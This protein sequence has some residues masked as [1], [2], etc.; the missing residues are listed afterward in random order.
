MITSEREK[1]Q[2]ELQSL[3]ESRTFETRT[4]SIYS[5]PDFTLF[6]TIKNIYGRD[7][8][9]IFSHN[10]KFFACISDSDHMIRIYS[11]QDFSLIKALTDHSDSIISIAFSGDSKYVA[12]GGQD[13]KLNLYRIIPIRIGG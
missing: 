6:K 1:T 7:N 5:L 2:E 3:S 12:S 9:A 10:G 11:T 8:S 13:K 4:A